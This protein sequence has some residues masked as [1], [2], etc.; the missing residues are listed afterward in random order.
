[1]HTL[2]SQT[3][4]RQSFRP[5]VRLLTTTL[6]A[7]LIGVLLPSAPAAQAQTI[8]QI[9]PASGPVTGGNVVRLLGSGFTAS[10]GVWFWANQVTASK[11]VSANE[12]DVLVPACTVTGTVD[13]AVGSGRLNSSYTYTTA[14]APILT[15]SATSLAFGNVTVGTSVS[16]VLTV[17]SSGTGP[18][19]ISGVA[20]S[21]SGYSIIGGSLNG[22]ALTSVV[23]P[24]TLTPGAQGTI[25]LQYNPIA[26]GSSNG[27]VA[28]HSNSSS[29]STL[30]AALT[31]I[32]VSAVT[33]AKMAITP[34]NAS[35]GNITVG[36]AATQTVSVM[37]SGTAPL[38]LR[39]ASVT[40]AGYTLSGM[41]FPMTLAV[42]ANASLVVQFKPASAG[43]VVGQVSIA[44]NA[45]TAVAALSGTGTAATAQGTPLSACGEL[46]TSGAYYLTQ[47][48]T[49]AGTCFFIDGDNISLNLNGFTINYATAG[50]A[51][52]TPA[53][54][55][56]DPWY[57]FL[58]KSGSTYTHSNFE[59]YGGSI[60]EAKAGA[61]KSAAIWVGQSSG[62]AFPK[63]HDL[64]LRT[65]STDASPIY[66][67]ISDSGWQIYNNKIYYSSLTISSRYAFYGDAIWIGNQEQ[68]AGTY[69]DLIYNNHIYSAPQGGIRDTHQNAKIYGNDITFNSLYT[70]DFC[71]DAP[72][73]AQQVYSNNC[74]P[75]SGRGVHTAG[76]NVWIHDNVIT[77]QE[78]KQNAEYG[79]CEL[80]GA[81]G[82]Q[83]EFDNSFTTTPPTGVQIAN[84]Q[85]KA[86]AGDCNAIGLRLTSMTVTGSVA[87]TSNIVTTS[88]D[89]GTG[90]DYGLSFS[91]D[92]EGSNRFLFI[93][94]TFQSQYAYVTVDWD[95]ANVIVPAGQTWLGTPKFA[96]DNQNGYLD[97]AE[98]G[99]TFAQAVMLLDSMRGSINCG[100]Y[101]A[102]MQR[103]GSASQKC[104]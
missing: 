74:H 69:T 88:N 11:L 50:G 47:N 36:K 52:P 19:S 9:V 22:V 13:V 16:K 56:A 43:T 87:Y 78:L 4:R 30:S 64:T 18:V 61:P 89:G 54:V 103:T 97:Q 81:Y 90:L 8:S 104:N 59:I 40:G 95:G 31:G 2:I 96:V 28:I 48:V 72:A 101:A 85:I 42:G 46:T 33:T 14:P 38:V 21:G 3:R 91:A 63:V 77:V 99:P 65:F 100:P 71:V 1:M 92:V 25:V 32:G 86:I 6:P 29:G 67:D 58:A 84:N 7:A 34:T 102:G 62:I 35:L 37:S 82:I 98:G 20:I 17:T 68:A 45:G 79:G 60:T 57:T 73:D 94:N 53:V 5:F 49:S 66:G 26:A 23:Y 15:E 75:T 27:A 93:T 44:S 41:T 76:N 80:G 83:V 70:N 24:V 51:A 55:L 12:I 39:S 10:T